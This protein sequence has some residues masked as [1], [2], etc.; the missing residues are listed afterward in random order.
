LLLAQTPGFAPPANVQKYS[1]YPQG[2]N[3]F[4]DLF[5]TNFVD[6][7]TT[8]GIL[9]YN[10]SDYTY[11]GHTGIDTEITNFTA[12][13]IGVPIFAALDGT[14]IATHD[15]EFDMNTMFNSLPAN[16]V[17]IDHGNGQT[18]TYF[19]MKKDSVAVAVGQEVKAG[20]QIGLT[21]SSGNSTWPHLHFESQSNGQVFEPFS[22]TAR[23]GISAWVSQ[24][25]F[26]TDAYLR[27]LVLTDQDL[28]TWAGLPFDTTRKGTFFTGVQP[29][30]TWYMIGNG[31][32]IASLT[33][34]FLRPDS[35]VAYTSAYS[36]G[37]A[38]RNPWLYF[39][40]NINFDVV[41]DWQF[42]VLADGE[43]LGQGPI[44]VIAPG[45]AIVNR[46][47]AEIEAAFDPP[48]P[49][50]GKVVF[51][52]ITSST[53]F[54]DPDYDFV[55]YHYVWKVNGGVV[56]DVI[57]AGLADAIP[58]DKF[59]TADELVCTVTPSD[60]KANG[61]ATA[62]TA[63]IGGGQPLNISTRLAVGTSDN[64]LIG[65]FIVTGKD[66]KK[67]IVRAIGPSLGDF[68][69]S[70]V[71][72]D[73][74]LELHQPDNTVISNDD[75]RDTQEQEIIDSTVPPTNDLESAIV[76]TLNPG[77]YTA[78]VQGKNGGTGIGLVEVYDLDTAAASQ[79][80]NISTRGLV[81]TG[82]NAMIGGFILG[83]ASAS[84]T[85]VVVRG[86]GPSLTSLGVGNALQDP[87]L[88]LHD[89]NGTQIAFD[90]DWKDSQESE[91]VA[92]GLA[93]TDLRESAIEA[94]LAPGPYTAVLRGRDN[95]TG[96][97]LV[98]A[99]NLY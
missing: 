7:D 70:G 64:V 53:V 15:G 57:S 51:C 19:H 75:W 22:G 14:V 28:S 36:F 9:A 77:A 10:G 20:D 88:E 98:E 21:A 54:L 26:R 94:T 66:P 25:P 27:A 52:R 33:M 59:R 12:Q 61:P 97:G 43:I 44:T 71:L 23:P 81:Q 17:T 99:Y 62:V 80:A 67:V 84:N 34:N 6:V 18:T 86:I 30:N 56:R 89:A 32:G 69:L 29:I 58:A 46:P 41:G 2:G 78:V 96:V 8:S 1:F 35:S 38:V 47:P 48:A 42:E 82:D 90:N 60:G 83:G 45:S 79:L 63:I 11:D 16:Y 73:P 72:A 76:A 31:E 37:G 68:G 93:P 95:T 39:T 65:G 85:T 91:I 87:T 3:F 74:T 55:R 92:S 49:V 24:P 4:Q 5:P 50:S 13:T 40:F